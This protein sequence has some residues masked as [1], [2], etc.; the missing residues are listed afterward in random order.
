MSVRRQKAFP[1]FDFRTVLVIAS[2]GLSACGSAN[3]S[4]DNETGRAAIVADVD[5]LLSSQDCAGALAIVEEYYPQAGCGTD[6]IR[7]ARASANACAANINFFQLITDLGTVDLVGGGIWT[8]LTQLFPSSSSDQR[9]T[10]GQ[11]ALDALFAIRVPGTLTPP[12][13]V[14][15]SSSENPGTLVASQRTEDSNLY[16]MLVSMSLV[17][18]LQ[19]RYGAPDAVFHKTKKLGATAG[20]VNGWEDV[21][22]VDVNACTYAGAV[23]TLFDSITQV[24]ATIAGSL[25][26]SAGSDLTTAATT[27]TSLLNAACDSAC[28]TCGFPAGSC[29]PC[30]TVLRDRNSCTGVAT[31]KASCAAAGIAQFIDTNV[32]GWP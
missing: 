24:S 14:I 7:L 28:Q 32:L 22:A 26:G 25:S 6:E 27:F 13:Y 2:L 17:G 9:V 23:L 5:K 21:T 12:E 4:C 18:A 20:N 11:N 10:A 15:N 1:V 31:D 3:Y 8:S 30:P 16:G 19:N 29:T